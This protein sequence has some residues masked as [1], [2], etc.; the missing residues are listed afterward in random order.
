MR[1]TA[2][3]NRVLGAVRRRRRK[4][5][6]RGVDSC[7]VEVGIAPNEHGHDAVAVRDRWQRDL[8]GLDR[9]AQESARFQ[10]FELESRATSPDAISG[11]E[12]VHSV[13]VTFLV[14]AGAIASFWFGGGTSLLWHLPCHDGSRGQFLP[15]PSSRSIN[16]VAISAYELGTVAKA[17]TRAE[18]ALVSA[19][20]VTAHCQGTLTPVVRPDRALLIAPG[21][22]Q[23]R[24]AARLP[25]R[26]YSRRS[27]RAPGR[28]RHGPV[29]PRR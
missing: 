7:D 9:H 2:Q 22:A 14:I 29:V 24:A 18:S 17:Y 4:R 27:R 21:L 20:R 19:A 10:S 15:R 6:A 8:L 5:Q 12:R 3:V 23:P 28:P 1:R 25:R 11:H 13:S 16:H 26:S